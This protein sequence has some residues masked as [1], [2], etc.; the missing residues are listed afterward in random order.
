MQPQ[1]D[2]RYWWFWCLHNSNSSTIVAVFDDD[3]LK[4][5]EPW[6]DFDSDSNLEP[7]I[8]LSTHNMHAKSSMYAHYCWL[9]FLILLLLLAGNWKWHSSWCC[10]NYSWDCKGLD[11][12]QLLQHFWWKSCLYSCRIGRFKSNREGKASR[13]CVY[14]WVS[15]E[16]EA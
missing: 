3:S 2:L 15:F 12:K 5:Q 13:K 9:V 6:C 14:S 8:Y 7:C 16:R 1:F 11:S 10:C 4:Y